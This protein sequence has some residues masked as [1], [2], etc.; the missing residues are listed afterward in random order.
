MRNSFYLSNSKQFLHN[1]CFRPSEYSWYCCFMDQQ[2]LL[3]PLL[4]VRWRSRWFAWRSRT[5]NEDRSRACGFSSA[6]KWCLNQWIQGSID[7]QFCTLCY[8]PSSFNFNSYSITIWISLPEPLSLD[9][10][11]TNMFTIRL[12]SRSLSLMSDL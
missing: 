6:R 9:T 10:T 11:V 12:T 4:L 7:L 5:E 1:W 8:N 2:W 3:Q